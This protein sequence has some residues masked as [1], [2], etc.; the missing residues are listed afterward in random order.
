MFHPVFPMRAA[1]VAAAA[2][3]LALLALA[4]L[5]SSAPPIA[6]FDKAR[7]VRALIAAH[8]VRD[9]LAVARADG[10]TR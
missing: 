5:S 8:V 4:N 7:L 9:P 1:F 10:L 3:A 2:A 6:S